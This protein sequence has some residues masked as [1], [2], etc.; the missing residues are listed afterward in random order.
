MSRLPL[1][2]LPSF[3]VIARTGNLRAA[4]EELHLTHSAVSQQLRQLETTLGI[5]LFDRRARRIVLN[6]AGAA[7]LQAVGPA[8]DQ[9]DAGVRAAT[10]AASGAETRLRVT[11][12][13]SFAQRWLLPRMG[14]WHTR[15]PD[16]AVELE[17]SQQVV[18]LQREGF[19]AAIRQGSG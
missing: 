19:H 8:L 10:A 17:A 1:H 16:I 15:H 2:T 6:A 11:L 5:E 3:R 7:L 18:D 9:I 4:A 13:P 12:L 14:D